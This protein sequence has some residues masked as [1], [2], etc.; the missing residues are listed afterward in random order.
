MTAKRGALIGSDVNWKVMD[1]K[2]TVLVMET[3]AFRPSL[4]EVP[5]N[6]IDM[7]ALPAPHTVTRYRS[8][9]PSNWL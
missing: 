6:G 4:T 7:G 2:E 8:V 9:S 5:L 1:K 3:Y